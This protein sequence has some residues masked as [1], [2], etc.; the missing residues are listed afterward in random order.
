MMMTKKANL[1]E[2]KDIK[3]AAAELAEGLRNYGNILNDMMPYQHI[4]SVVLSHVAQD[5]KT[6]GMTGALAVKFATRN[7]MNG[8]YEEGEDNYIISRQIAEAAVAKATDSAKTHLA[9]I[10]KSF[11]DAAHEA[12]RMEKAINC[13]G[14]GH[15]K[16]LPA[17][18]P[19][20][21][22]PK[23]PGGPR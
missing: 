4:K 22:K 5:E 15:G 11:D 21:F 6:G 17:P 16:A 3:E 18:E 13:L 7:P 20:R 19:A 12:K 8:D 9:T 2:A 1:L 14:D 10:L 23:A